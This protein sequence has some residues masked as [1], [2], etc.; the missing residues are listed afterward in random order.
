MKLH[1]IFLNKVNALNTVIFAIPS[2]LFTVMSFL[3][4]PILINIVSFNFWAQIV[5]SQSLGLLAAS[6]INF[7]HSYS[8]PAESQKINKDERPNYLFHTLIF[9]VVLLFPVVPLFLILNYFVVGLSFE[10]NLALI[11]TLLLALNSNQFLI[12]ESK[13]AAIITLDT[14]PRIFS[15]GLG[16]SLSFHWVS[17]VPYLCSVIFGNLLSVFL[18]IYYECFSPTKVVLMKKPMKSTLQSMYKNQRHFALTS[19]L[20]SSQGQSSIPMAQLLIPQQ[21]STYILCYKILQAW[22]AI[23]VPVS[24][25][26]QSNV[27][28]K[29]ADRFYLRKGMMN[30]V[31]VG[32]LMS[33]ILVVFISPIVKFLVGQ[34]D[35]L[36]GPLLSAMAVYFFLVS[37]SVHV[38]LTGLPEM[39]RGK[40]LLQSV[41]IG[42][43][44]NVSL[45]I[46][47]A[48]ILGIVGCML[49]ICLSELALV[50]WQLKAY[51][52]LIMLSTE[53]GA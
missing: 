16:L 53:T 32:F 17:V 13:P 49:A 34:T 51:L 31:K 46:I 45:N 8:L 4:I 50:S 14:L 24:H 20:I 35:T 38:G 10:L 40:I 30:T 18:T 52:P 28:R 7:G 21:S 26:I 19:F 36:T 11:G 27:Y 23:Y 44:I 15:V 29:R 37:L 25:V 1:E 12:G 42:L 2:A 3:A 22:F 48:P 41:I 47:L 9:R 43:V 6:I 5:T 33:I 39:G